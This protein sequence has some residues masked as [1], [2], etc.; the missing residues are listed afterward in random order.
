MSKRFLIVGLGNPGRE[1][2]CTRHNA[3]FMLADRL[4]ECW[5]GSWRHERKF[6]SETSQVSVQGRS[7]VLCKPQTFMNNS[8]EAVAAVS[9]FYRIEP[10]ETLVAVDDADI[11]LGTLRLRP[12]GGTGG[13]HGLES[14]DSH[15]GSGG[16]ARM[17]IGIARPSQSRRDIVQHVLGRLSE[18]E[19]QIFEKVL[20]RAVGQAQ[21]WLTDGLAKA[22]NQFN[23]SVG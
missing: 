11:P 23:G 21:C 18:D 4:A 14:I 19:M 3:G 13:H 17:R 12:G 22:M 7:V 20:D 9:R 16:Y 2:V 15:V 5:E 6:F 8:G 10:A 1:Y